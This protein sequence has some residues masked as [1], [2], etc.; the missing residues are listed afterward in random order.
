MLQGADADAA[1]VPGG[2]N[3]SA[4]GAVFPRGG[5][6]TPQ[7]TPD[8]LAMLFT[9]ELFEPEVAACLCFI[10]CPGNC[11]SPYGSC[12][13]CLLACH[14]VVCMSP[15]DVQLGNLGFEQICMKQ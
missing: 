5:G 4:L 10:C 8:F 12:A 15:L 6:H 9:N 2:A 11:S 13:T 7:N 1:N 3:G 14:H